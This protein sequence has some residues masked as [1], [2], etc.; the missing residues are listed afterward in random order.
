VV[1]AGY[2]IAFTLLAHVVGRMDVGTAYAI[3]SGL[4]TAAI[5]IVS[6]LAYGQRPTITALGGIGLIVTGVVVL[7]LSSPH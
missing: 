3:W 1:L 6:A 7:N 4:G 2:A 5:V